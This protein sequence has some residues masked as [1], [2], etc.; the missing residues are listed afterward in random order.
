[1]RN[2]TLPPHTPPIRR[3]VTSPTPDHR[4]SRRWATAWAAAG[5]VAFLAAGARSVGAA[6]ITHPRLLEYRIAWNDIPAAGAT[7]AITPGGRPG[8]ERLDVEATARTNAFVD[9]FWRFRGTAHATLLA[10]G[11]T[12][13]R[14]VYA[15]EMAGT[16]SVT[17]IDFDRDGARS[18][19]V[20]G[21]R[22]REQALGEDGI[23]DPI[24][25]VFRA[26]LSGAEPGDRLHYDVWTGESRYRVQLAV[27]SREPID[28]PAGRFAA[29]RVVP[30]VWKVGAQP[31]RD[32]RLRRATIWVADDPGRTLLRIRSEIFIG[33]VTLD[34]VKVEPS[35]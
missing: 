9:L 16:P 31:E 29:L 26:R 4:L 35:A 27:T 2:P 28:V 14:F 13:L 6:P 5:C 3:R 23:I 18:V 10:D 11:L 24:T 12:P 33:A 32:T 15:R 30:E 8:H 34:L 21:D 22:R 17:S 20:K 7:V 1:M 25:A 19:Y